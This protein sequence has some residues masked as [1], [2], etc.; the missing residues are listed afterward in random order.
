MD[1]GAVAD[2]DP[3]ADDAGIRIGEMQHGVVLDVRVVADDDA[4]DIAAQYRAIP[5]A[6]TRA[7]GHVAEHDGGF[8]EV[9]SL[10]EPR[11]FAQESVELFYRT[12]HV[13]NLIMEC[14]DVAD[15][16]NWKCSGFGQKAGD[17][18]T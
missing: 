1:N 4:V 8:G 10:A 18:S 13:G 16:Y 5:D 6:R 3:V 12:F 11:R 15:F 2:G 7:N 9:N 17:F 14:G